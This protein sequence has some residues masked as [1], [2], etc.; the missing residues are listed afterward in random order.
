[1]RQ[2]ILRMERVTYPDQR[3]KMLDN[4]NFQM[5]RGEIMGLVPLDSVGISAFLELLQSNLPLLYGFVYLNEKKVNS[6]QGHSNISENNVQ[7]ISNENNLVEYLSAA[8]NVFALRKGYK[9]IM[10]SEHIFRQQLQM[11]LSELGT[12]IPPELKPKD[13]TVFQRY[14]IEILKAVVSRADLIVLKDPSSMVNPDDLPALYRIIRY[15]A[16]KGMSFIYVSVYREELRTICDRVSFMADGRIVKVAEKS[17]LTEELMNR[18]QI[19]L[20]ADDSEI[21]EEAEQAEK[22][23]RC[24]DLYYRSIRGLSFSV[25]KGECLAIHD[26]GG[27]IYEDLISVLSTGRPKAGSI[28]CQEQDGPGTKRKRKIGVILEDPARSM[29]YENMSYVDNF[30]LTMDHKIPRVWQSTTTRKK[31]VEEAL[32]D[33]CPDLRTPVK[34]LTLRQKYHLVYGRIMLQKPDVVF[35][36]HPFQNVDVQLRTYI[37]SLISGLL[38]RQ[39]AVVMITVNYHDAIRL[40]DR[41]IL[42]WDGRRRASLS[43]EEIEK[44]FPIRDYD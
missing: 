36:V 27:Q 1:M 30:C 37:R 14:V 22:V 33:D 32:G 34:L 16:E 9:S 24:R 42:I 40:A 15:Y 35:I 29:V 2:E 12:D 44:E 28:G 18:F 21:P 6:Y 7:I 10:V 4:F 8:D 19:T 31:I 17:E 38:A 25:R 11:I 26:H 5:F 41:L 43:R 20:H 3:V 39:I 23:F 13:M